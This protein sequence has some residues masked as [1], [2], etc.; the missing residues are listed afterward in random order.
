MVFIF[1]FLF[2]FQKKNIKSNCEI[3]VMNKN[4]ADAVRS[5]N[6]V[7]LNQRAINIVQTSNF[8]TIAYVSVGATCVGSVVDHFEQGRWTFDSFHF[9]Y[10]IYK[11]LFLIVVFGKKVKWLV[12]LNMGVTFF[13]SFFYCFDFD[14]FSKI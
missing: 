1:L 14:S 9:W 4:K 3:I 7:F 13:F 5:N 8:G 11:Y 10:H 6:A 12:N 2:F